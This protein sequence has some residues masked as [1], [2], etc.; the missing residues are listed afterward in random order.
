MQGGNTANIYGASITDIIDYA[1]TTKRKTMKTSFGSQINNSETKV[2][3]ITNYWPSTSAI[4]RIDITST[5][6]FAVGT[7]FALYGIK[8]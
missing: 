3:L 1:S 2:G 7:T 6:T 5:T 8:G 4:T